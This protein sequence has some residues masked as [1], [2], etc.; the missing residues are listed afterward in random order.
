LWEKRVGEKTL[1]PRGAKDYMLK[2]RY[3]FSREIDTND[4]DGE[5]V[6]AYAQVAVRGSFTINCKVEADSF[7]ILRVDNSVE[8]RYIQCC[9]FLV[10]G[11]DN[12][13]EIV[14]GRE[15]VL[16]KEKELYK[17]PRKAS[18]LGI[19]LYSGVKRY[20]SPKYRGQLPKWPVTQMVGKLVSLPTAKG[21]PAVFPLL[22]KG[23]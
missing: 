8:K 7:A 23:H 14:E 10:E 18:T 20:S 4:G 9:R 12:G 19:Y 22:H 11:G 15:L 16:M 1:S 2:P 5:T 3:Q 6:R 21:F 17:F 13:T